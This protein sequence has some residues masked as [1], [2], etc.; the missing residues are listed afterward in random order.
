MNI[1][2]ASDLYIQFLLAE[3]GLSPTTAKA[4]IDDLK[5][6]F[7]CLNVDNTD[8]IHGDDLL[9]FLRKDKS[10]SQ[11]IIFARNVPRQT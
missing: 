6:F 5:Q 1:I 8:D 3:K 2:D 7:K 4:Y 9:Y 10:I 11:N